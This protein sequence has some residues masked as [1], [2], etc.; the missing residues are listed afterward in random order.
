[1]SVPSQKS[2]QDSRMRSAEP[3]ESICTLS[4][5]ESKDQQKI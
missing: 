1:M 4:E 3:W 2:V 5:R